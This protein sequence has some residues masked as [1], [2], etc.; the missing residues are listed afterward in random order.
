MTQSVTFQNPILPG[1]Y[2]DPSVIRV[3]DTFYMINSSFQ[4]FPG[5][6]IHKS[7]NLVHWEHIGML[8]DPTALGKTPCDVDI[9]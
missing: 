4:F 3:D 5:L 7:K 9:R 2:P 8:C 1:F 6:P